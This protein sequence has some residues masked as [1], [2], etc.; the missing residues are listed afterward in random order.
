MLSLAN[1]FDI[2]ELAQFDERVRKLLGEDTVEYICEPKMDGLAIE[3]VFENG[4]FTQG[5]TRGDG[6]V[7]ENVTQNLKTIRSLPFELG[8]THPPP[9][10]EVRGEVFMNKKD[11]VAL[12]ARREELGEP[13]FV[14][15][16][17]SAAGSLRQLDPKETAQRPLRIFVYEVG[18]C[19]GVTFE[20]HEQKL[21][22]LTSLG[23]PVSPR[24][25]K[26]TGIGEVQ[27][28]YQQLQTQRHELPFEID[29]LVVKVNDEEARQRLGTVS[30]SPRWAV[31]YKFPPEEEVTRVE[32][33]D[34]SVGRTGALTP[35]AFL[36]PV[37]V[38]GVTVSKATLHNEDELRR[39][40][41]R[42]GDFVCVRRAGDVIPEVVSV[43]K[44]KRTGD[45]KE[46]VFPTHC[47][48]CHA[49]VYKDPKDV[50]DLAQATL[51]PL[52]AAYEM[53]WEP[54]LFVTDASNTIVARGDIVVDR[55]EMAEM[56][57][58]AV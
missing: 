14:N 24:R 37:Y 11:F 44:E 18:V 39:K 47:P 33:I 27:K 26:A 30:K 20:S 42:I 10:L 3:L 17:N 29:G 36:K 38:G 43:L 49:E 58:L 34:V 40:D 35:V 52:P 56:L 25:W 55:G 50:A 48:V 12:N 23:L 13:T 57:A 9:Y 54:S 28:I 53:F 32:N 46:F 15:P 41:I 16:R 22:V 6:Q 2:E 7:G 51:A 21:E 1:V 5:S 45:E 19:E 31:A 8:T 4:Q